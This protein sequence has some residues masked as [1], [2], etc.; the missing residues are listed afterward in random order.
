MSNNFDVELFEIFK[1]YESERLYKLEVLL[2]CFYMINFLESRPQNILALPPHEETNNDKSLP[3]DLENEEN[4]TSEK[5]SDTEQAAKDASKTTEVIKQDTNSENKL[6][7]EGAKKAEELN[8]SKSKAQENKILNNLEQLLQS[9]E[10][11]VLAPTIVER[12]VIEP[13]S[14][15]I[16]NL[17]N[18][19]LKLYFRT[20]ESNLNFRAKS[21]TDKIYGY[22]YWDK[23]Q[24]ARHLIS[25]DYSKILNDK[26]DVEYGKGKHENIPLALYFD[27]SGSMAK[28]SQILADI[29]LTLL[30]NNIKVLIGYNSQIQYQINSIDPKASSND[31]EMLF[32][33]GSHPLICSEKVCTEIDDYLINKKC[34]RCIIVSDKDSYSKV[35]NLSNYCEIYLLYCL[36]YYDAVDERF[37][38]AYFYINSEQDIMSALLNMSKY[39]Y[40]VLK[41][42]NEIRKRSR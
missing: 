41:S 34:E 26:Y 18:K 33:N 9:T 27:L 16:R 35:C 24:V 37:N 31:L 39:N 17:V 25:K 6:E 19:F 36:N 5:I 20:K 29:A 10:Q 28:Y 1:K 23:K 32:Q 11:E 15:I 30:K 12:K 21:E 3:P 40:R 38:G 7:A 4:N 14:L 42:Q 2:T 22:Y 8:E 13:N